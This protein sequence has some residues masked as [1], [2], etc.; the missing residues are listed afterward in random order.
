MSILKNSW[1]LALFVLFGVFTDLD[2]VSLDPLKKKNPWPTIFSHLEPTLCQHKAYVSLPASS[3]LSDSIILYLTSFP[4]T[5]IP[6][7]S[8]HFIYFIPPHL[9]P[10]HLTP[11]HLMPP[12]LIS[13]HPIPSHL[14]PSHLILSHPL[15]PHPIST[16][17]SHFIPFDLNS[18]L[19]NQISSHPIQSNPFPPYYT[20]EKLTFYTSFC[21]V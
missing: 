9:S 21:Y 7:I 10:S 8:Y 15:P 18:F 2:F 20:L 4:I 6:P 16:L 13:S 14:T 11:S 3:F 17:L 5:S 19:S 1:S 12:H